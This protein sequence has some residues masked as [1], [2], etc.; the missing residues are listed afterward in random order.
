MATE[1]FHGAGGIGRHLPR[2]GSLLAHGIGD[3]ARRCSESSRSR[4]QP[5]VC[6]RGGRKTRAK[7]QAARASRARAGRFGFVSPPLPKMLS[8]HDALPLV[9]HVSQERFDEPHV[10]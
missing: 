9:E 5:C 2:I 10:T 4:T 1:K 8:D 6:E 3:A 7:M